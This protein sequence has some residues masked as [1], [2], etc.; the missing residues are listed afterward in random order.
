[1]FLLSINGRR[2]LNKNTMA[3]IR[4]EE[5]LGYNIVEVPIKI[6]LQKIN[7]WLKKG[8]RQKFFACANPHS[9]VIATRDETFKQALLSADLLTPDGTGIIIASKIHGGLIHKR[10]TGTDVFI[11][12]CKLLNKSGGSVFFLGSTEKTLQKIRMKIRKEYPMIKIAGTYSPTFSPV[13][14]ENENTAMI[15]A[16]NNTKPNVLWVGMTAPKQEKWIYKNL[17]HLD[18]GFVGAIGAVFDFYTGKVKRSHP[19]F[20]RLGLEWLPRFLREPRRLWE[21]NMKSTPIFLWLVIKEKIRIYK[22]SKN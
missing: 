16:I 9:F 2:G 5:I 12:V 1:M 15:K 3:I 10:I 17:R 19:V 14:T 8:E 7:F 22:K 6:C 18:V 21:R 11:G 20:Q 4:T 13:F